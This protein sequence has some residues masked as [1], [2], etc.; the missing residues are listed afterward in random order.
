MKV[1]IFLQSYFICCKLLS[2]FSCFG[3]LYCLDPTLLFK[4]D[5]LVCYSI[6]LQ[7]FYSVLECIE[8]ALMTLVAYACLSEVMVGLS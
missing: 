1:G 2:F 6:C 5:I 3:T 7:L 4:L 8:L